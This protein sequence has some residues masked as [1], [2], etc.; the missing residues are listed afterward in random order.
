MKRGPS[1][2]YFAHYSKKGCDYLHGGESLQHL[3]LKEAL[4]RCIDGVSGWHA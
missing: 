1:T 3:A 2:R 4:Q